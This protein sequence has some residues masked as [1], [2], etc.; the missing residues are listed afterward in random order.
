MTMRDAAELF[1]QADVD[2]N[3]GANY[4]SICNRFQARGLMETCPNSINEH[5]ATLNSKLINSQ[6]FANGSGNAVIRLNQL[7]DTKLNL[8]NVNGQLIKSTSQNTTE[9]NVSPINLK[10][11]VY[12]VE[13]I[14]ASHREIFKLVKF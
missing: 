6:A 9:L 11:G 12:L 1:Y 13:I 14:G 10:A 7:Q 4:L 8:Y 2:L 5:A 3:N